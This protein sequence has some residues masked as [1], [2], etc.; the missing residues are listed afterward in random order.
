VSVAKYHTT[1]AA[2]MSTIE[3]AEWFGA[4]W[5]VTDRSSRVRLRS[6]VSSHFSKVGNV[7]D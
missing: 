3:I 7:L 5:L 6:F 1:L 2:V 4:D